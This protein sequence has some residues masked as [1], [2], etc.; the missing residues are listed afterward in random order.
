M[1]ISV[2]LVCLLEETM[3]SLQSTIVLTGSLLGLVATAGCVA[4]TAP[5]MRHEPPAGS[6]P[7][8]RIVYVDDGSCPAG[9]IK[10][11]RGGSNIGRDGR[12]VPGTPR[13]R[14]CVPVR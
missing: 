2:I 9:Q 12:P 6:V 5:V 1:R 13:Q 7:A 8:G 10:A 3:R 11:I 14:R 4:Q